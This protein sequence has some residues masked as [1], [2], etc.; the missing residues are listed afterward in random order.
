MKLYPLG[1]PLPASLLSSCTLL[2]PQGPRVGDAEPIWASSELSLSSC[3]GCCLPPL[4]VFF[5]ESQ[6]LWDRPL[7][8]GPAEPGA[9]GLLGN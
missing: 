3:W 9:G 7:K 1:P 8:A 5:W 6:A 2:T 4:S